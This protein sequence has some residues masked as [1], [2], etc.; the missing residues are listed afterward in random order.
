M[1]NSRWPSQNRI[2]IALFSVLLLLISFSALAASD[3]T[4]KIVGKVVDSSGERAAGVRAS[5][6][7]SA[8][9]GGQE[10]NCVTDRD[11]LYTFDLPVDFTYG[12][13]LFSSSDGGQLGHTI[14]NIHDRTIADGASGISVPDVRISP[15]RETTVKVIDQHGKGVPGADV[16]VQGVYHRLAYDKSNEQGVIK[17]K[18]PAGA[19]LQTIGAVKAGVGLDYRAFEDPN[20]SVDK[21]HPNKLPQDFNG[22]VELVLNGIREVSVT[23]LTPD[24]N[25]L[26][27]V[28]VRPWLMK[29]P[30]R[31]GE[32]NLPGYAEFQRITD[33]A[34]VATFDMLA[35]DQESQVD[36]W[37]SLQNKHLFVIGNDANYTDERATIRWDGP[38]S[39]I[40]KTRSKIKIGGSVKHADETPAAK[41][42]VEARGGFHYTDRFSQSAE[43]DESGKWEMWVKPD[44]YYLLVAKDAKRASKS[45]S[46]IL[47][48]GKEC[49]PFDFTLMPGKRVFGKVLGPVES[50]TGIMLQQKAQDYY[51]LPEAMRLPNDSKSRRAVSAFIQDSVSLDSEGGFEFVVGPGEFVIWSPDRKTTQFTLTHEAK[52]REF[53]F[54]STGPSR[55]SLK[56]SVANGET[57]QPISKCSVRFHPSDFRKSGF[58]AVTGADGVLQVTRDLSNGLLVAMTK[59]NKFGG[60]AS[61]FEVDKESE[62]FVYATWTLKG[63][64]KDKEGNP[65]EGKPL[66]CSI[67]IAH[68]KL[69]QSVAT[70]HCKTDSNGDFL[71]DGLIQGIQYDLNAVNTDKDNQTSWQKLKPII[72]VEDLDI[73]NVQLR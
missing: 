62:I 72:S 30:D 6:E 57:D 1:S 19:P 20:V 46:V 58:E 38:P 11:G 53:I 59:D 5:I 55:G 37:P 15:A 68:E 51:K 16:T 48:E 39:A 63:C 4:T 64:L 29:K 35:I 10:L 47:E 17:L 50:T 73:G 66:E 21:S 12:L 45:Y 36:F 54:E 31:G 28:P 56:V 71:I 8:R 41:I 18:Y 69:S 44:G 13:I 7:V 14:L 43:T 67:T 32:W 49:P 23:I 42:K 3:R 34:G 65:V 61:I 24:G 26:P 70:R 2:K 40:V 22:S 60:T 52:D 33:S 25:P 9:H 27:G